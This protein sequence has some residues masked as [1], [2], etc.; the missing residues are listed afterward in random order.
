[1]TDRVTPVPQSPTPGALPEASRPA[2]RVAWREGFPVEG[3]R[4]VAE[5]TAVAISYDSAA[6]AVLMA[7]PRDLEDFALGFSVTEGIIASRDDIAD[8]DMVVVPEGV[9]VRLWLAKT[10][11]EALERRR[12]RLAGPMGCGL[13]GLESLAEATRALPVVPPGFTVD[14]D[15]VAAARDDLASHQPLFEETRAVHAAGFW[16]TGRAGQPG[17]MVAVREDVGR[18][19]A[20]D[21]LAGAL[22][23]DGVDASAGMV[24]MSSRVS[25]ELVQ[26]A[27]A[28]GVPVLVAVSAPSALAIRTAE[29]AGI[30]L[31]AVARR[32]GFE[33]FTHAGRIVPAR[34]DDSAQQGK[35]RHVA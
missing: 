29:A 17:H 26:K 28:M 15:Q 35:A 7:T 1:M 31:V 25:V 23:R 14:A 33:V 5:E 18:H 2:T 27:A 24:V 22:I 34:N 8:L 21:K 16:R 30:T 11:G 12:R 3:T 19:N 20:L 13:C 6:Y 4:V 10:P 9:N 32:D